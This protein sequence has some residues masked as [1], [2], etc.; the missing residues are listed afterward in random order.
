ME[1]S[2]AGWSLQTLF[3]AKNNPLKLVDYPRFAKETFGFEAVELNNLFFESTKPP[4]LD[5]IRMSAEATGVKLLNIAVDEH[6]ELSGIDQVGRSIA[7]ANYSRWI[8]IA[9][10][11]GIPAIRANSGGINA[12]SEIA[13][14]ECCIDSFRRLC[15]VGQKHDVQILIENHSG[16]SS[17]PDFIVT[18]VRRVRLTHGEHAIGVLADFGNWPDSVERYDAL[19]KILPYA[20]ATHAKVNDIDERLVHPRFDHRRCV[21][22]CRDAGYDGYLGIE[23]ESETLDPIVGIKRGIE[24]LRPML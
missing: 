7:V 6:G 11:M 14:I 4:Y 22:L 2:L 24:L 12:P 19:H 9:K 10:Y 21:N 23:F 16:L 20:T 3:W 17:D 8:P 15:D 1:L 13:A 18:L 5:K